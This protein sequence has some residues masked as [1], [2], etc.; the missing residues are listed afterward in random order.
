MTQHTYK[1]ALNKTTYPCI[2][3]YNNFVVKITEHIL[4]KINYLFVQSTSTEVEIHRLTQ[5]I[6]KVV[7]LE[8]NQTS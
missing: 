6:S 8:K 3:E 4:Y 2:F 5:Y 7:N 1:M